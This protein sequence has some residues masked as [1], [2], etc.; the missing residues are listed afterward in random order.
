MTPFPSQRI[1]WSPILHRNCQI[2]KWIFGY[3]LSRA[4]RTT[5]NAFGILSNRFRVLSS[6][7]YLQPNHATKLT[8]A[9]FVL[10]KILRTHSKNSYSPSG[11]TDEVEEN[12]NVRRGEWRDKRF[13]NATPNSKSKNK[14]QHFDLL[15]RSWKVLNFTSSY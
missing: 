12:R 2:A 9:C 10:H 15:T 11:F 3:R 14:K 6:R 7:M 8:L 4:R 13:G 5:E 1:A